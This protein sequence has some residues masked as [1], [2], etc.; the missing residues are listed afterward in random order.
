MD[1]TNLT[2][3]G[4][5]DTT[6]MVLVREADLFATNDDAA[7]LETEAITVEVEPVRI[8][9]VPR[10]L[11]GEPAYLVEIHRPRRAS[12][13]LAVRATLEDARLV[14]ESVHPAVAEVVVRELPLP[15]DSETLLRAL[16]A[17]R[18]WSRDAQG[19]W[20]PA[21]DDPGATQIVG[22]FR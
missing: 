11:E 2:L 12:T 7:T 18:L 1:D 8:A 21:F 9:A 3:A 6:T 16:G 14:A 22:S 19:V 10:A 4:D 13:L 17:S 5:G 20:T 15:C